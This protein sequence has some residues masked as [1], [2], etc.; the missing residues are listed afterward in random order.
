MS[1]DPT[2][3]LLVFVRVSALLAV[4]PLFSMANVPRPV[5]AALGAL[6]TLLIVP[7]VP[8]LPAAPASFT[9]LIA[10]VMKEAGI[11]LLLGFVSRLLFFALEFAGNL[12]ATEM[13]MNMGA[14]LNPFSSN[15]SEAPGLALFHL[16]AIIFL[17]LD[18]HHWLLVALQRTYQ[19]L[20]IGG[21]RLGPLLFN[22]IVGRTSQL[23][24][25]GLLMAAPVIAV[26]FLINV[27]F[28]VIGRAVPQMNIFAESFAI[29]TLAGLSVFGVTLSLMGQH[30][31]NYLRRLPEDLLRVAQLI[32]AG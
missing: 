2:N 1:F 29:R 24:V 28:S 9:G 31:V 6:V 18:L 14:T 30:I 20:P 7:L 26:T 21:A 13:G 19:L 23:F 17:T 27:V 10:L 4:F 16:G 25:V 15:R 32:G 3:W 12:I 8:A 5:R 11:G 22:D